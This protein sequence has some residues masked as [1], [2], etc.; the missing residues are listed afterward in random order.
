MT[1]QTHQRT[2]LDPMAKEAGVNYLGDH[3]FSDLTPIHLH[4]VQILQF[5]LKTLVFKH[6][7]WCVSKF[8]NTGNPPTNGQNIGLV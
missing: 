3:L 1:W 6:V 2:F 7:F 4:V 8:S 5:N